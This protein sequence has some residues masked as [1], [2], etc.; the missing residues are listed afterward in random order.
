MRALSALIIMSGISWAQPRRCTAG[1]SPR[2]VESTAHDSK[3]F[4]CT[5]VPYPGTRWSYGPPTVKP[6]PCIATGNHDIRVI[7]ITSSSSYP[8][9][10]HNRRAAKCRE[11]SVAMKETLGYGMA[12]DCMQLNS[13]RTGSCIVDKLIVLLLISG[14]ILST[15]LD[16]FLVVDKNRGGGVALSEVCSFFSG[17]VQA[18]FRTFDRRKKEGDEFGKRYVLPCVKYGLGTDS[19]NCTH[20]WQSVCL[21]V[22]ACLVQ[23]DV[24]EKRAT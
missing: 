21:D 10:N 2:F 6:E 15:C 8:T 19:L 1:V 9:V 13:E 23:R 18:D 14:Q 5:T 11:T 7:Q 20:C 3:L 16:T 4:H 22:C 24:M 12:V 17:W